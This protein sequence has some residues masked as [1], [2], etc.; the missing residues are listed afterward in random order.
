MTNPVYTERTAILD[1]PRV[2]G[3]VLDR[4]NNRRM[5]FTVL[6]TD[7]GF[8]TIEITDVGHRF[9]L[10]LK[11]GKWSAYSLQRRD[12]T[13]AIHDCLVM[14][15][16]KNLGPIVWLLTEPETQQEVA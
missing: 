13:M 14:A 15:R 6:Q 16:K 5:Y 2:K 1:L 8:I 7:M 12:L 11:Y 3:I 9:D 10:R 4:I